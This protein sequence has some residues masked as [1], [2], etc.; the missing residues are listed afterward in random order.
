LQPYLVPCSPATSSTV[1]SDDGDRESETAYMSLSVGQE[2]GTLRLD[3][4]PY[5]LVEGF[6]Q[7]ATPL[8]SKPVS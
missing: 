8:L 1:A 3:P 5:T 7:L 4:A 2:D 6:L